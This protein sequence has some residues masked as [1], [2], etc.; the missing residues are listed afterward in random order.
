MVSSDNEVRAI[1]VRMKVLHGFDDSQKFLTSNTVLHGAPVGSKLGCNMPTHA[2]GLSGSV[3][4]LLQLHCHLRLCQAQTDL[5]G[6]DRLKLS[7]GES[8]L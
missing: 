3:I 5:L 6:V 1:Q 4:G 8:L 2:L 7:I